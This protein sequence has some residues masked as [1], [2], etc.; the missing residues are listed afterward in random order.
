MNRTLIAVVVVL[1]LTASLVV[2]EEAAPLSALA[3]M[4]VKEI[5]VF[6]DGHAFV[7][8]AGRMPTDAS[9]NVLMDYLPTPVLGT[10]WPYSADK[11]AKLSA[12]VASKRKVLIK[13]TALTLRELLEANVGAEVFITETDA[14]TYLGTIMGIP[15][16]SSRELEKVS[17]PNSG[18][19]L[20]QKG[21]LILL[22]TD[23]GTKVV[24]IDRIRD[25][26]FK[27]E[28]RSTSRREE[29]RNLLTLKLGWKGKPKQA[30]DVGMMYLQK[31]VRWIPHYKITLDSEGKAHVKLQA[32]IINELTD[33]EG[34]TVHLVVGVPTFQF[35][36][37]VDPISLQHQAAQLSQY[38]RRS[39]QTAYAMSNAIMSQV[40]YNQ[41]AAV[42][43]PAGVDLGPAVAGSQQNEDL[44]VF[45]VKN[46]TLKKGQRMV[47]PVTEF[48]IPYRDVYTLDI[49]FTPPAEVWGGVRQHYWQQSRN[50]RNTEVARM[51]HAPK[52]MHKIR[53]TNKSK[54]PLTTAPALIFCKG[55]VLAQG[56]MQ[57]TSAGSE[58]DLTVTTA[59]DIRVEKDEKQTDRTPNAMKWNNYNHARI[60]LAGK[61]K[62][63]NYCKKTAELE[64]TRHVLGNVGKA[65]QDGK[66]EM[67]NVLEDP[68]F[69]PSGG[70]YWW[71]W[72]SWP[73]W[74]HHVNGIGRITWKLK[75]DAGKSVDLKYNWYY[76][77]R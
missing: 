44:F 58:V 4:P 31:G 7:L 6:K 45:D 18:E 71:Q 33:L 16:R 76:Y 30:A 39:S 17:P 62:L 66:A 19:K 75:L 77:W 60:D 20:P 74:W 12:V 46:V 21:G 8:H 67:V 37:T 57:Y 40:A 65:D 59:V 38:F 61:I 43:R 24:K 64:I 41:P 25:I 72:Y 35:K 27:G 10:F 11:G 53:L 22:K 51:F 26:T 49:P 52:V 63:T 13:Q 48:T 55:R 42:A 1:S 56:M 2:A 50:S 73:G 34:V 36:D 54:Y 5:T 9:G 47:I 14:K 69:A 23:N 29:F 68:G 28:H 70:R 32:T 3:K 15:T